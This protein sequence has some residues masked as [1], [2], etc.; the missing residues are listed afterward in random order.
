MHS[1]IFAR[2]ENASFL[3]SNWKFTIFIATYQSQMIVIQQLCG[4]FVNDDS[5]MLYED[6]NSNLNLNSFT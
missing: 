5:E 6:I 3:S 1:F 4:S 2:V